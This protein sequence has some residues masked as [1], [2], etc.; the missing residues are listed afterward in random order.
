MREMRDKKVIPHLIQYAPVW[1]V[2]D[3]PDPESDVILFNVVFHHARYGW[4]NRRYRYDAFND[5]LYHA[6]QNR[7]TEDEVLDLEDKKP[8]ITAESVNTV[9]SYGG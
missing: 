9:D 1:L 6:G 4:V 3:T 5:V 8:Y 2:E 7:V